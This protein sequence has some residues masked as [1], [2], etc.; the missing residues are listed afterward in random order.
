MKIILKIVVLS[1][2]WVLGIT[3]CSTLP[4]TALY[5]EPIAK[6]V[7][8]N[9]IN[10]QFDVSYTIDCCLMP[11]KKNDFLSVYIDTMLYTYLL[12]FS[13]RHGM[14]T[15]L[16]RFFAISDMADIQNKKNGIRYLGETTLY[17][18]ALF[19]NTVTRLIVTDKMPNHVR[20]RFLL[21]DG[22][23]YL[24]L[25]RFHVTTLD[26]S[27]TIDDTVDSIPLKY[28]DIKKAYMFFNDEDTLAATRQK[29]LHI[30]ATAKQ[31]D[32]SFTQIDEA[33]II[34]R[35]D[36]ATQEEHPIT[37][38]EDHIISTEPTEVSSEPE[39]VGNTR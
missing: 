36:D 5:T 19:E 23:K 28:E 1:I 8:V 38:T 7:S 21:K 9:T 25:E 30:A 13:I 12:N 37:P 27:L 32:M 22:E 2:V 16:D 18:Y 14:K 11:Q 17:A 39:S 3:G 6:E 20:F 10:D 33:G 26:G 35:A 31:A 4:D 29:Q 34:H 15:V 24:L